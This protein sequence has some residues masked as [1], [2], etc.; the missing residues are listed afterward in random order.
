MLE[1]EGTCPEEQPP[2]VPEPQVQAPAGV[3]MKTVEN[4]RKWTYKIENE[5]G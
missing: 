5:S 2:P 3:V 4:S 1:F